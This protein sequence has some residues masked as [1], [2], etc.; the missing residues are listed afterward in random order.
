M[1]RSAGRLAAGSALALVLMGVSCADETI[2]GPDQG[3]L[4]LPPQFSIEQLGSF[5][6]PVPGTNTVNLARLDWTPTGIVVPDSSYIRVR[7]DGVVTLGTNPEYEQAFPDH[8]APSYTGASIPPWGK[9]Y[10][11]LRVD[12]RVSGAIAQFHADM[13]D[14]SA[15]EMLMWVPEGGE[16]EVSRTGING[17]TDDV[18]HYTLSSGQS[19]QVSRV[20]IPARLHASRTRIEQYDTV[21]FTGEVDGAATYIKL[22]YSAGD[23]LA[24]PART[25]ARGGYSSLTANMMLSQ[26]GR[27]YLYVEVDH[28][29]VL[30]PSE[31]VWVR[32]PGQTFPSLQLNADRQWVAPGEVVNF[33]ASLTDSASAGPHNLQI[34]SWDWIDSTGVETRVCPENDHVCSWGVNARGEMRVRARVYGADE[35]ATAGVLVVDTST[36]FPDPD[37]ARHINVR[38]YLFTDS[39]FGPAATWQRIHRQQDQAQ[40]K[41]LG[42]CNIRI[43]F[44]PGADIDNPYTDYNGASSNDFVLVVAA[45][46]ALTTDALDMTS[47]FWIPN[48]Y[49]FHSFVI[50]TVLRDSAGTHVERD[51]IAERPGNF[52]WLAGP[53]LSEL[54]IL[55]H[56]LG[57]NLGLP[58][59]TITPGN[60]MYVGPSGGMDLTE[61]QCRDARTRA[62][63][64]EDS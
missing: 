6:I 39:V 54:K 42:S 10:G 18:G 49:T 1:N 7:V 61:Q 44:L 35:E 34:Q 16:V 43:H 37:S 20:D 62:S 33:T 5:A 64:V 17:M 46:S 8:P 22:F 26:S 57:H 48:V 29:Y 25:V 23:T 4:E 14:G 36:W 53:S 32:Q 52:S 30:V 40:L 19:M 9:S 60:L 63:I 21:R 50:G 56:E 38:M 55:A 24:E 59:D 51:G 47:T 41:W 13:H 28:L 58:H 27:G 3:S 15:M 12:V 45:D 31:V 11:E 2:V